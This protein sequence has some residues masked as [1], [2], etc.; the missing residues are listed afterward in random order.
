MVSCHNYER[1][2][3]KNAHKVKSFSVDANHELTADIEI[4]CQPSSQGALLKLFGKKPN[5]FRITDRVACN[6]AVRPNGSVPDLNCKV[7]GEGAKFLAAITD[8][9]GQLKIIFTAVMMPK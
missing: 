3:S 6:G 1:E 7:S 2:D 5:D 4:G 8:L 9:T